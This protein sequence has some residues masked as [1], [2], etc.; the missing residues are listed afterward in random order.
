MSKLSLEKEEK[1]EIKLP[2]IPWI[3]EK[4]REFQKNIYFYFVDYAKAFD[5]VNHNKLWKALKQM[6]APDHLTCLL[7]KLYAGQEAAVRTLY[8][9]TDWFKIE[10]GVRQGCLHVTLFV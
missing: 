8:G 6:R 4:A 7:R 1:L 5:S 9:T 10:K 2:N 3:V